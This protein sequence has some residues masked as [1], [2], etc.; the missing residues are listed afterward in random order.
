MHLVCLVLALLSAETSKTGEST[1][2]VLDFSTPGLSPEEG[3]ALGANLVGVVT[4]GVAKLGYKVISTADIN[5][6]LSFEKQKELVGCED[7]VACLIEIGGALGTDLLVAGTVGKLGSTFNVSLTL[8]DTRTN[9]VRQRFQGTAGSVE[10]LASTVGRGVGVL[11]GKAQ[12]TGGTATIFAKTDPEGATVFLDGKEVGV[13]PVAMDNVPAGDH[14]LMAKKGELVGTMAILLKANTME[15]V[16][17]QL[18]AGKPV[19]LKILSTPLEAEVTVDGSSAGVTPLLLEEV[20]PGKHAVRISAKGFV[21]WET[22]VTLSREE[23]EKS[24]EV[25]F[26]VE[27]TLQRPEPPE[28]VGI[29]LVSAGLMMDALEPKAGVAPALEFQVE[30]IRWVSVGVG[31]VGPLAIP[32]TVRVNLLQQ[33]KKMPLTA[34]LLLRYAVYNEK[35]RGH[36]RGAFGGGVTVSRFFRTDWGRFG[37]MLDAQLS[38]DPRNLINQNVT[39]PVTLSGFWRF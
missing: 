27:A 24:G 29:W 32:L 3:K 39:V 28:D 7:K 17:I 10:V 6:M 8:I 5:A 33:D 21:D 25:P 19:K 2:A 35:P 16:T 13:A 38:L 4:S 37:V 9:N 20:M 30:P 11:F 34:G 1:V 36:A 14:E 12:D 23:Y 18:Q 15:R 31:V 26:K 22:E